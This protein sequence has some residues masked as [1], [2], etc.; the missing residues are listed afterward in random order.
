MA[1]IRYQP[2]AS[3]AECGAACLAMVLTYLGHQVSVREMRE[4]LRVGR[5]G[6]SA[7]DLVR[8]AREAGL[9][10]EGR[11]F[12]SSDLSRVALPGIAY[13]RHS[14]FVVVERVNRRSALIIDPAYGRSKVPLSEFDEEFGGV[15]LTFSGVA[16]P[17]RT[18]QPGLL[19]F[20][21]DQAPRRPGALALIAATSL[22]ITL[23]SM[24]PAFVTGFT[25]DHILPRGS[26]S[27]LLVAGLAFGLVILG[28]LLI[29]FVRASVL[30][31]LQVG[32]DEQLTDRLVHHLFRLPMRF[33]DGRTNGDL[34]NRVRSN[35]VIR[36]VLTTQALVVFL[37]LMT[38]L[39]YLLLLVVVSPGLA[40]IIVLIALGQVTLLLATARPLLAMA[41]REIE[42]GVQQ[43]S[44]VLES[45]TGIESVK[46]SA[47]EAP[48]LA[49]WRR[50]FSAELHASTRRQLLESRLDDLTDV[51][52][53]A[54]TAGFVLIGAHAV[55]AGETAL[56]AMLTSAYIAAGLLAPLSNL[57]K[58]ARSLQ[59]VTVHLARLRDVL[60]EPP[61]T[62]PVGR[63]TRLWYTEVEL[64]GVSFSYGGFGKPALHDV[65]LRVPA[66]SFVAIAGASGSGKSTLARL[67]L[68]LYRPDAGTVLIG[69]RDTTA[70]SR[71]EIARH[72]GA[73]AQEPAVFSGTI[74]DNIVIARSDASEHEIRHAARLAELDRDIAAMPMGYHTHLS[75]RGAGLSGG[76]RQRLALA[77]ALVGQPR[78]LILDEA[79]SSVDADT[80]LS[81]LANLRT[82][83]CTVIIIA[84]RLSTIRSA[85]RIAFMAD[86]R[87]S[88]YGT[89]DEL[90]AWGGRYATLIGR[91]QLP[92]GPSGRSQTMHA[93]W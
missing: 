5:D 36:Q 22:L 72:C 63:T 57:T 29:G 93:G 74:L 44:L 62:A 37:D 27:L 7:L 6:T 19:R 55:I 47:L 91:Q 23:A 46:M 31:R 42:F 52:Q 8:A 15:V 24:L 85:D 40:A 87:I 82:L 61:E 3:M 28:R 54:V 86:G 18:P 58:Q 84:H 35:A 9:T 38:A 1:R 33:Y 90:C 92:M 4:R 78:L 65:S 26:T 70:M 76:Q 45:L 41:R 10:A 13:L 21:L 80:E 50:M 75:E 88:E 12:S 68:G 20:L 32:V 2:Q 67:L 53:L 43:Q 49:R 51:V 56:G 66:G 64:R 30:V 16:R 60:E 17:R 69:G 14:H 83:G 81:I 59:V 48:I 11:R 71:E 39:I 73:V 25:I 79:T 34:L 77:R 89:H